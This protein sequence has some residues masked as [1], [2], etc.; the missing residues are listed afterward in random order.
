M[1][2]RDTLSQVNSALAVT[3]F[4]SVPKPQYHFGRQI[5]SENATKRACYLQMLADGLHLDSIEK[6]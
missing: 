6:C 5:C 3:G 1:R 4:A 2:V